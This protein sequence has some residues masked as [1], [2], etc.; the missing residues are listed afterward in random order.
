M[1]IASEPDLEVRRQGDLPDVG[2]WHRLEVP[3]SA[4]WMID[5]G[6]LDGFSVNGVEFTQ[7]GGEVEWGSFGKTDVN[8]LNYTYIGDDAP[9]GATLVTSGQGE[10]GWPWQD[11][12]GRAGLDVPDF[13]TVRTGDVRRVGAIDGFRVTWTQDFLATDMAKLD[14]NGLSEFLAEVEGRLKATNDAVDLG[15]VRARSDI[16]R[17][18][19]IM[20]GAD[21]AS[22]LVTSPSLADLAARDEGARATSRGISEFLLNVGVLKGPGSPAPTPVAAECWSGCRRAFRR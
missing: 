6:N 9:A 22:R 16:Y 8:G 11:V 5:G 17:V 15:F 13:G 1:P 19:Q 20:L 14:E 18:R 7:R 10:N 12:E 2:V 3:A 4:I 21:S